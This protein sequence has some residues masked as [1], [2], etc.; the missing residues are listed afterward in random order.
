VIS[1]I[2]T[3]ALDIY[4]SYRNKGSMTFADWVKSEGYTWQQAGAAIGV[5]AS[6]A[7]HYAHGRLPRPRKVIE[8]FW[9]SNRQVTPNDWYGLAAVE[10]EAA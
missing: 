4:F 9:A 10:E 1:K 5:G 6:E 2:E 8:I 3:K 7:F